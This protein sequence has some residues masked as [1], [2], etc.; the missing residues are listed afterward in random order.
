M[1]SRPV[2]AL[3][4]TA[5]A[6]SGC[7]SSQAPQSAVRPAQLLDLADWKLTLPVGGP[8]EGWPL[9]VL[10]PELNDYHSEFF[11]PNPDK[12]AVMFRAPVFGM[13]QPGSVFARTELREMTAAGTKQAAWANDRGKHSM[14]IT[15]RITALPE[16]RP[17]I[18]AGQIH[19]GDE[20]VVLVRLDGERLYAKADD[21]DIGALDTN[22]ILGKTFTVRLEAADGR[23]RIYYDDELKV[24]YM[25]SCKSC[26][27][28]AGAY[29]QANPDSGKGRI[30][31]HKDYGEVAIS[32]L[33]VEHSP[34]L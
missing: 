25:R 33:V 16:I 11:E 20:Y 12:S 30:P 19:G 21:R 18:V 4:I 15:Q 31:D 9:E 6:L 13:A 1:L 8:R 22:Y 17:S 3:I 26:Y 32:T 24:D 10:Q 34:P 7:G 5:L 2:A 23:I 14:V 27:F 28:K 29:L